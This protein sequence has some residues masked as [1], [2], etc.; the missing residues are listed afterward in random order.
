MA[1]ARIRSVELGVEDRRVLGVGESQSAEFGM[2]LSDT[3]SEATPRVLG[4]VK[5]SRRPG[6]G[7]S[8]TEIV[9]LTFRFADTRY[10]LLLN[11]S[12]GNTEVLVGFVRG[13]D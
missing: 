10:S 5:L 11:S 4:A 12:N 1:P 13:A 3:L 8:V 7:F 9:G 2:V 6:V